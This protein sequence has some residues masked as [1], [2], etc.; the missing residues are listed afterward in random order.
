LRRDHPSSCGGPPCAYMHV[1][2]RS[3]IALLATTRLR[4]RLIVMTVQ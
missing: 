4:I 1:P 3:A 2:Q